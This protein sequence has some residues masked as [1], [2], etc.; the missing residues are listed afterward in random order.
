MIQQKFMAIGGGSG[1]NKEY[2]SKINH[3]IIEMSGKQ[4]PFILFIPTATRDDDK[5][6]QRFVDYFQHLGAHVDVL[7]L[8]KEK[9]TVEQIKEKFDCADIIYVGGGNTLRMMNLW[10]K[11]G[12]DLFLKHAWQAGKVLCGV[13]AGSICW[14]N[15]GNSDSRKDNNPDADYINVTALGFL[16]AMNCP[17]YDS[18]S[19][20]KSSFKKML[21]KYPGVGI[22]LDDRAALEVIGDHYRIITSTDSA[23]AYKVYWKNGV[24]YED[25]LDQKNYNSLTTLLFK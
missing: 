22:A 4:N 25:I 21:K 18:E 13:S 2:F 11:F 1:L 3:R 23:Q 16:D 6:V 12:V 10:R 8:Y 5:Y 15:S 24:F 7:Y 17:H 9:P 19:D 20:R 14:F